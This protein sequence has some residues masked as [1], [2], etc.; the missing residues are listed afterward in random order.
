MT[1]DEFVKQYTGRQVEFDGKYD[2]QCVDL[3]QFYNRDVIKGPKLSGNAK[4]YAR[5]QFPM[6]YK[7]HKNDPW[8]I[9]KRGSIAVWNEK[10]GGGFG[11]VAIVLKP[12][13][14]SFTSLDQNWPKGTAV[15]EVKHNYKNVVG[16]LIPR[17]KDILSLYNDLVSDIKA[18]AFKYRHVAT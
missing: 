17:S 15:A 2:F 10:V 6:V 12:W 16:F 11:H 8:Y 1:L 5:N 4:D 13:L 9:P 14:M 7:F 3:I 18:V